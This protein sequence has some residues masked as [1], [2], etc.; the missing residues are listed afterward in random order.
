M[1]DAS[2]C[3]H[4]VDVRNA[5]TVRWLLQKSAKKADQLVD[6]LHGEDEPD[7][8]YCCG[9]PAERTR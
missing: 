1:Q 9:L 4:V 3:D 8:P 2:G 5:G 7:V 6:D